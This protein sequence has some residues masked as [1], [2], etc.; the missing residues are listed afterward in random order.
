MGDIFTY[1]VDLP[2]WMGGHCNCNPDGS[3]SIFI[4]ARMGYWEQVKTYHHELE[5]IK[6]N[7]F[8]KFN[9]KE[10][11]KDV[12]RRMNERTKKEW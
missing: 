9:V 11:E 8:E 12:R 4:N 5:H 3:Y 10:I 2:C 6:G 1:L 7:D